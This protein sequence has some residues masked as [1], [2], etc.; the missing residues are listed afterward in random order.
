M[1]MS[2]NKIIG[3]AVIVLVTAYMVFIVKGGTNPK[4]KVKWV[5]LEEAQ[6]L[7]AKEPRKIFID[8][9]AEWCTFCKKMDKEAL[10]DPKVVDYI[11]KN[12]YPVKLDGEDKKKVM[13]KGKKTTYEEIAFD[14]FKVKA[15]PTLVFMDSTFSNHVLSE[16]YH[17]TDKLEFILKDYNEKRN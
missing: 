2:K 15:Y 1:N 13:F 3:I 11:N 16:G 9:Y 17:S 6:A 14:L 8:V 5:T 4:E 7:N 10:Q 12:Y